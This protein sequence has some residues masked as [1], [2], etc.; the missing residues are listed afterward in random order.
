MLSFLHGIGEVMRIEN[1]NSSSDLSALRNAIIKEDEVFFGMRAPGERLSN[2]K[3]NRDTNPIDYLSV[4]Q[5]QKLVVLKN[6][7]DFIGYAR[8]TLCE[9]SLNCFDVLLKSELDFV[10]ILPSKRG[11]GSSRL[12]IDG[13]INQTDAHIQKMSDTFPLRR[14]LNMILSSM[15]VSPGGLAFTNDYMN[16]VRQALKGKKYAY[17]DVGSVEFD[18]DLSSARFPNPNKTGYMSYGVR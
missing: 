16:S 4:D 10:Y 17:I 12:L 14:K 11:M 2:W 3:F 7:D 5:N 6:E 18:L 15:P 1:K 8:I 9:Q 13:L